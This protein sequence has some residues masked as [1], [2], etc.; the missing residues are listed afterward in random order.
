MFT[1]G[2]A[3]HID[4]GKTTLCK[5][6]TGIETDR[7][8]EEKDRGISIELGFAELTTFQGTTVGLVDV[9]GHEKFIKTMVAGVCGIDGVLFVIAA[10]EGIMPQTREH[11]DIIRL[12]G[13]E[14]GIIVLTKCDMAD[15][16]LIEIVKEDIRDFFK[17]TTF[18][19]VEII[20]TSPKD[21]D[22]YLEVKKSCDRLLERLN[23]RVQSGHFRIYADRAFSL[24]GHGTVITGTIASGTVHVGDSVEIL[25]AKLSSR[26]RSIQCFGQSVDKAAGGQR[27]A[28]NLPGISA[29]TLHRGSCCCTPKVF[30]PSYMVDGKFQMLSNL[31]RG[32][33]KLKHASRVRFFTGTSEVIGRLH[34]LDKDFISQGGE[35]MVQFR[36]EAPVAVTRGDR[37]LVRSFSPMYTIGGGVVIDGTP[38]KHKNRSKAAQELEQRAA[39]D[40][41]TVIISALDSAKELLISQK[42]LASILELPMEQIDEYLPP[43]TEDAGI[44]RIDGRTYP[45]FTSERRFLKELG[46]LIKTVSIY[47]KENDQ[48]PG[49][50]KAELLQSFSSDISVE[51]FNILLERLIHSGELVLSGK[52]VALPDFRPAID[53]DLE[54]ALAELRRHLSEDGNPLWTPKAMSDACNAPQKAL[55][56]AIGILLN[57]R[58][59][60][61]LPGGN[62]GLAP[63]VDD[64]REKVIQFIKEHGGEADTNDIKQMLGLSRKHVIPILEY[65]DEEK[66]TIRSG[67]ARKLRGT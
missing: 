10:D 52:V 61:R 58:E 37:F 38:S 31:P 53:K 39:T 63:I 24:K 28:L 34:L 62:F 19:N 1:L 41:H 50:K 56:T 27:T 8:Q 49:I 67:N 26:I 43:Q 35:A 64:A 57:N 51:V 59:L 32:F 20:E 45:L 2:T 29:S 17:N 13:I 36:L 3:G 25:P 22:S 11:F 46:R 15:A 60:V 65:L 18:K 14:D 16:D 21:R 30:T 4:H 44:V 9:P 6:L 48:Q 54:K 12:M 33:S 55:K 47:H 5:H 7:L 23:P 40:P 66:I 42:A